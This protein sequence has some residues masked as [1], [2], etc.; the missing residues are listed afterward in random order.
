MQFRSIHSRPDIFLLSIGLLQFY[1][2]RLLLTIK[3][4]V[5][6]IIDQEQGQ[7]DRELI[8]ELNRKYT[9]QDEFP[10]EPLRQNILRQATR[11][12]ALL[13]AFIF[14]FTVTG[15]WLSVFSGPALQFLKESWSL[16]ADPL[17][18]EVRG[19][20][21]QVFTET[22]TGSTR[23]S[24]RGSGF[25]IHESGLVVTNRHLVENA[26][27]IRVS[28]PGHGSF[29]VS[30]W[31]IAQFTDLALLVFDGEGLPALPLADSSL[32]IDENVLVIGN[33]LQFARIA[34]R[35]KVIAYYEAY[36][37]KLPHLV[38]EAMIYPGSS[39]SPVINEK[40]EVAAVI[41]ATLRASSPDQVMG[42]AIDIRE[43]KEFQKSLEP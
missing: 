38:I 35:G 43:L 7:D 24:L 17:V 21:V 27:L 14:L 28:F 26:A 12:I 40:G 3:G 18:T 37:R 1:Q 29:L 9:G 19:A 5:G 42:L 16:S 11:L 6:T 2:F 34:N 15:R 22:G 4:E 25:N 30:E 23:V 20:V 10:A 13:L 8:D 32:T 33:P 41:F 39:G 36:G 31:F